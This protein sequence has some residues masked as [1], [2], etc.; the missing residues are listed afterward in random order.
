MIFDKVS[1]SMFK[2]FYSDPHL[3]HSNIIK[4]CD[5][6]F[7]SIQEMNDIL[8]SNYNRII[9]SNDIV[10]WLGDCFLKG[11]LEDY[12]SILN[13]M[14]GKKVLI[15]GNHDQ[16]D[17]AMASLG[18]ELVMKEAVMNISGVTC[19]IS[20]YP[21]DSPGIV[22]KHVNRRPQKNPGEIL[23]HGHN[24]SKDKITTKRSIS[25]G[26]DAW[27][28]YP[29]LYDQVSELVLNLNKGLSS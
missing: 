23:I 8:I 13:K 14:N 5:R 1:A 3:G 21:Y 25:V 2:A 11:T 7:E 12:K 27:N 9:N 18:F 22:D 28:F 10:L 24:H 16:G 17:A 15:V 6:P 19:R 29:A 26:V 4:Y 20:H